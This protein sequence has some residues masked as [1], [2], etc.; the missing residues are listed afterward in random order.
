MRP[1][2]AS[3]N[4]VEEDDV[5]VPAGP[6]QTYLGI[7][8]NMLEGVV[9]LSKA[10]P[11]SLALPFVAAHV[12]ECLL[13]AYLSRHGSDAEVKKRGVRH[14]LAALWR[15]CRAD[16]LPIPEAPEW[17]I[18]LSHIHDEPYFL[19]YSTN[20]HGLSTPGA[21]PMTSELR[22]LASIVSQNLGRPKQ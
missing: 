6:P 10:A 8:H 7:A 11:H 14:N 13:K 15:M 4:I 12:L 5:I 3:A 20:V 21:E 16:G 9:V 1:I 17:V 2:T 18:N 22:G 19:R